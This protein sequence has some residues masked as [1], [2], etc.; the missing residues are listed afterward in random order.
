MTEKIKKAQEAIAQSQ[1]MEIFAAYSPQI[2]STIFVEL[3]TDQSDIDV[4]CE[5]SN[6]SAFVSLLTSEFRLYESFKLDVSDHYAMGRFKQGGF[7]FELYGATVPVARQAAYRHY[8][9]M[10]RLVRLAGD[11][12]KQQVR[13]LKL[14]GLKTEPAISR[15]LGLEG[16]P[17]AAVLGLETHSDDQLKA[18]V[19]GCL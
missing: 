18:L 7:L 3:D 13:D 6:Q 19:Q 12:F 11:E 4:I 5:Y 15:I 1:V 16:E 8:K 9:V 10:Q 14:H 2:V 17:Y